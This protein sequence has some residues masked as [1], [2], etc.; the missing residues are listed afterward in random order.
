MTDSYYQ[1]PSIEAARSEAGTAQ[2]QASAYASASALL[3]DKLK[4]AVLEKLNYNKDLIEAQNKSMA[5]YFVAP[6]AAREKYQDIFNPFEREKLVATSRAQAYEPYANLTDLLGQRMGRIEDIVQ[7]GTGAYQAQVSASQAAA[8]AKRREY[9]DALQLAQLLTGEKQ[10]QYEQTHKEPAGGLAGK[11]LANAKASLLNDVQGGV[12]FDELYN[13]YVPAGLSE[14]EIRNAYN[15]GPMA[16]KYG[17]AQESSADLIS[18][19]AQI[20]KAAVKEDTELQ[21]NIKTSLEG[22]RDWGSK[23]MLKVMDPRSSQ[24]QQFQSYTQILTQ[25]LVRAI[26]KNRISWQEMQGYLNQIKPNA[27]DLVFPDRYKGRVQGVIDAIN[28][29]LGTTGATATP[30]TPTATPVGTQ[31]LTPGFIPD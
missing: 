23:N 18:G 14:Y 16:A 17:P 8:D 31:Q 30:T 15:A 27:L 26:E 2:T 4:Q 22:I 24:G 13:R 6:S 12:T 9:E 28:I 25:Y 10:W 3:P 29:R 20:K 11:E 21:G 19:M 5:E 1:D 7:A